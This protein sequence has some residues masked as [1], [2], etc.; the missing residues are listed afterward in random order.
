MP[1][2][3]LICII[4]HSTINIYIGPNQDPYSEALST[5]AK[6]EKNSLEK[7]VELRTGIVWEML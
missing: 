6:R 5:Q 2:A 1:E 3:A 7:V 4:N